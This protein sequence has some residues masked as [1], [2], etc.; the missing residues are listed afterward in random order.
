MFDKQNYLQGIVIITATNVVC[1]NVH[2]FGQRPLDDSATANDKLLE[3][4]R[5]NDHLLLLFGQ[6][7]N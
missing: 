3:V 2:R 4:L 5:Q 7:H 1:V 6:L